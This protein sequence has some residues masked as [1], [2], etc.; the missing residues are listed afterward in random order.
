[1]VVDTLYITDE[2]E[3]VKL[4]ADHTTNFIVFTDA[5]GL[6]TWVNKTFEKVTEYSLDE[7]VGRKPGDVLQGPLTNVDTISFMSK[8]IKDAVRFKIDVINYTKSGKEYW[9]ELDIIPLKDEEN[10][11]VGYMSIQSDVSNVKMVIAE[12]LNAKAILRTVLDT[13]PF[14][15][16]VKDAQGRFMFYNQ[17]FLNDF[18]QGNVENE[19]LVPRKLSPIEH[20][21]LTTNKK[22]VL[23]QNLVIR[24]EVRTFLTLKFPVENSVG[25]VAMVGRVSI[26]FTEL[27]QTK[28]TLREQE[29]LYFST[30]KSI[31][32]GLVTIDKDFKI[33]YM[34][35]SAER[36]MGYKLKEVKGTFFYKVLHFSF[37]AEDE[38]IINPLQCVLGSGADLL[39][40][41]MFVH[42]KC[43][44]KI[45]VES[46][47]T[48]MQDSNENYAGI[49]VFFKDISDRVAR[50][51]LEENMEVR[52]MAAMIEGQ[53]G[54]RSRIAKELHDGLGQMLNLIKMK[55]YLNA[56]Q[57]DDELIHLIDD[58]IQEA[59]RMSENLVPAKLRDFDLATALNALIKQLNTIYDPKISFY[60]S[61][62]NEIV[63]NKKINLYRIAQEAINNALKHSGATQI[64]VSLIEDDNI[65]RLSIEDN[66]RG[67][68]NN[69]MEEEDLKTKTFHHGLA[70]MKERTKIMNGFLIIESNKGLGTLVISEIPK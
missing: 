30:V 34:N 62:S 29:Q 31:H 28:E 12:M 68:E 61:V 48:E 19:A 66:G 51:R 41:E 20:K 17:A 47:L 69:N 42:S 3:R 64:S 38:E 58:T 67:I 9:V 60:S 46:S 25:Q 54:E 40:N 39:K 35:P 65:I 45:P 37:T 4:I 44:K 15:V 33:S 23:E 16:S 43:G 53:E 63:A 2:M 55:L 5:D 32:D 24:G 70:N 1:M 21:I 13:V 8:N 27:K 49:V 56:K 52:R 11:L 22:V 36:M 14:H 50:T 7:V 26:D 57:F 6:I 59:T 18:M 10:N